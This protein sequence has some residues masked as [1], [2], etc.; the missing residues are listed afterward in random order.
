MI[1]SSVLCCFFVNT[2]RDMNCMLLCI[3]YN[4]CTG[5]MFAFIFFITVVYT[6]S[7]LLLRQILRRSIN[8]WN[9]C[10]FFRNKQWTEAQI[11]EVMKCS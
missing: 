5:L 8:Q 4:V 2:P 9:S 7:L 1:I 10:S 6:I 11:T 3:V